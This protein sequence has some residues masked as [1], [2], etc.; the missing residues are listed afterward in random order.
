MR[1]LRAPREYK[2]LLKRTFSPRPFWLR[3]VRVCVMY[4]LFN[5]AKKT[6]LLHQS[7]CTFF[8]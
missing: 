1:C 8:T 2:S 3:P 5:W 4:A 6:L 7:P